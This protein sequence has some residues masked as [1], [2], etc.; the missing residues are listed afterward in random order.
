[1]D[2]ITTKEQGG[3]KPAAKGPQDENFPV[4]SWLIPRHMRPHIRAFY[5]FARAADDIADDPRLDSEEKRARLNAFARALGA[6]MEED[7]GAEV[8]VEVD[9]R[10]A[11]AF[12]VSLAA[13]DIGNQHAGE[14]LAAFQRDAVKNR[15][16]DWGEL[17]SYCR[18]SA[19]PCARHILDLHGESDDMARVAADALATALQVINHIQDCAD[20]YRDLDRVYLPLEWLA[21]AGAR[22][23]DLEAAAIT[24]NL[25]RVLDRM[26]D[27]VDWLLVV[28]AP[29]PYKT[30]SLGLALEG[31]VTLEIARRLSAMLRAR[32]PLAERVQLSRAGYAAAAARGVGR[33][34]WDRLRPPTV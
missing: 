12:A 17:M 32:D 21:D 30:G 3:I 23:E 6:S 29:F 1:M 24:P 5:A 14:L 7:D 34:L 26:L 8:I 20:D 11:E 22:L 25:R 9:T 13:T 4:A 31:A 28:A 2:D 27:G 10:P 16:R 33:G 15:Y 18:L 19:V